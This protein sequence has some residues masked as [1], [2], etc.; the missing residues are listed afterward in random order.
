MNYY[1]Y[2]IYCFLPFLNIDNY[3]HGKWNKGHREIALSSQMK[4]KEFKVHSPLVAQSLLR[5]KEGTNQC[6]HVV[7]YFICKFAKIRY[8]NTSLRS[9]VCSSKK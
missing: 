7:R 6:F 8:F 5:A 9:S 1:A 2:F 3:S 4:L